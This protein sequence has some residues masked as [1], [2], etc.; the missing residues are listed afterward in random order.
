MSM[1][2]AVSVDDTLREEADAIAHQAV[3]RPMPTVGWAT[4]TATCPH[5]A[6]EVQTAL[7][8]A[9]LPSSLEMTPMA[10][11]IG[12]LRGSLF[13]HLKGYHPQAAFAQS[14][15]APSV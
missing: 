3:L 9:R 12:S 14:A 13:G 5:C 4:L 15:E 8:P 11:A 2:T 10:L 7:E 6:V 1:A